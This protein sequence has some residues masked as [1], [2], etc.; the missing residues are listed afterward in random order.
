MEE[1]I[2]IVPAGGRGV[3][4]H[5]HTFTQ[6]L[7]MVH[8]GEGYIPDY[9]AALE[10]YL[11]KLDDHGLTHGV[12]IQP[13]FLGTDN[14]NLLRAVASRPER[15]RCMVIVDPDIPLEELL[16][17]KAGG[18]VGVRLILF[19][20][21]T[22]DLRDKRWSRFLGKIASLDWIVEIYAPAFL[23][24]TLAPA[25]LEHGC[26]LLI[27][28]YGRPDEKLGQD[29]PGFQYLLTL[30]KTGQVWVDISGPYRNGEGE[31]GGKL[32]EEYLQTL[33]EAFGLDHLLWGS[34][35]PCVRYE[36]W[37]NYDSACRFLTKVLP[38]DVSRNLVL[39]EAPSKLFQ[40]V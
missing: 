40:L 13:S 30:A 9:D 21:A 6:A 33:R 20:E 36:P 27:D 15:L 10:T 29:D 38:D 3:D 8:A 35:W 34:D 14:S 2:K 4:T 11:K 22:P 28:H 7:T 32:S 19:G 31:L 39:W 37:N 23:L 12:L 1:T 5:A 25:L 18:A 16:R 26:R 24:P 17:L